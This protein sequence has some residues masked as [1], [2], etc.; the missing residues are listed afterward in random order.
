MESSVG[1][2]GELF[3]AFRTRYFLVSGCGGFAA[4]PRNQ[5]MSSNNRFNRG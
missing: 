3:P 5:K 1:F 4:A 2:F